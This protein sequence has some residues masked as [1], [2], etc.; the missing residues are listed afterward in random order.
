MKIDY[1]MGYGNKIE[2]LSDSLSLLRV[3]R[4]TGSAKNTLNMNTIIAYVAKCNHI[5]VRL[6]LMGWNWCSQYL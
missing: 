6:Q 2:L 5:K 1:L 3:W 4:Q